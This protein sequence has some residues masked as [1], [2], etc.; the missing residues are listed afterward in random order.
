M[1]FDEW[2]YLGPRLVLN[3]YSLW[4]NY[5]YFPQVFNTCFTDAAKTIRSNI[6]VVQSFRGYVGNYFNFFV[7]QTYNSS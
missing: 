4:N 6:Y 7:Y 5:T 2:D 1:H 3:Q